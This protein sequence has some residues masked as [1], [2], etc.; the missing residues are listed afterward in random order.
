MGTTDGQQ[1]VLLYQNSDG[2]KLVSLV[3]NTTLLPQ[4]LAEENDRWRNCIAF[5]LTL[6]IGV[7][8]LHYTWAERE[9]DHRQASQL[10]QNKPQNQTLAAALHRRP[11]AAEVSLR[12]LKHRKTNDQF[13]SFHSLIREDE[14]CLLPQISLADGN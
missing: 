10:T 2:R 4:V 5:G 12:V 14:W 8:S 7:P 3:L 9:N 1:Y 6:L 13:S 11:C